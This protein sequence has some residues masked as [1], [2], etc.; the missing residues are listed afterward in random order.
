MRRQSVE[1]WMLWLRVRRSPRTERRRR[2]A[3]RLTKLRGALLGADRLRGRREKHSLLFYQKETPVSLA[4]PW[5]WM[6]DIDYQWQA[7]FVRPL[8]TYGRRRRWL[9][10]EVEVD[11][12][13]GSTFYFGSFRV[14]SDVTQ[15]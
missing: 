3:E 10:L 11:D 5:L 4:G 12:K 2:D 15:Q 8:V 1:R 6:K 9:R 7:V 14:L 13:V